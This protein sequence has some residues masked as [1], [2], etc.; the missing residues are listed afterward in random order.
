MNGERRSW[1][2]RTFNAGNRPKLTREQETR[3]RSKI[4]TL[5]EIVALARMY[6]LR[7]ATAG[8]VRVALEQ[9]A[10]DMRDFLAKFSPLGEEPNVADG[11]SPS[12]DANGAGPPAPSLSRADVE[13]DLDV[14]TSP[15]APITAAEIVE[16]LGVSAKSPVGSALVQILEP[17]SAE[18]IPFPCKR[19]AERP[20]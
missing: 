8:I 19:M 2:D 20:A 3:I 13:R 1:F 17:H 6:E 5:D 4:Q 14:D 18:V 15:L 10:K 7:G 12:G 9:R 16:G 11:S